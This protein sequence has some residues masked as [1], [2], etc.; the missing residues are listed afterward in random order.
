M[1]TTLARA[2]SWSAPVTISDADAV[3][4]STSTTTGIELEIAPP[5]AV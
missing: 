3:P 5:L 2:R 1:P 4:W